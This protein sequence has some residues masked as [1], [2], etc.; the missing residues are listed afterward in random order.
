MP[1]EAL[2][3][4]QGDSANAYQQPE[5]W[6]SVGDLARRLVEKAGGDA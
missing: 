4:P 6:K 2:I 3:S 5:N 1:V